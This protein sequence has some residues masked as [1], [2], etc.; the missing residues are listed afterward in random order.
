M[1]AQGLLAAALGTTLLLAEPD[2]A[3]LTD[4]VPV[5]V[6]PAALALE[7]GAPANVRLPDGTALEL[8]VTARRRHPSGNV[9]VLAR[10]TDPA[11][12][13][14][15][16]TLTGRPETGLAGTVLAPQGEYRLEAREG[17]LQPPRMV[18]VV[19]P[20]NAWLDDVA[21][22]A[23][24]ASAPAVTFDED[25]L[26]DEHTTPLNVLVLY[27]AGARDGRN[28]AEWTA[29]LDDLF[30]VT[31]DAYAH[32]GAQV[33]FNRVGERLVAASESA[34]SF[35][36]LSQVTPRSGSF[37]AAVFGAVEDWRLAADAH[38]VALLRRWQPSQSNCGAAGLQACG[39]DAQCYNANLGYSVTSLGDCTALTLA[40]E[41][42]HNLGSAH[43]PGL[44]WGGTYPYAH[45]HVTPG[46]VGTVMSRTGT[47]RTA[48]FSSPVADCD[49]YPCG[50]EEV[51]DN[52][53][54][55][56]QSRH[57]I[58]RWISDRS[59]T[60]WDF[61]PAQVTRGGSL[62]LNFL[63]FGVLTPR[64]HIDLHRDGAAVAR[65]A[66]AE[67]LPEGF[68][69]LAIPAS[70][71][72]GTGYSLRVTAA[73]LPAIYT[74]S[75]QFELVPP[76]GPPGVIAMGAA[77]VTAPQGA[78][79]VELT[80]HRTG[81][82]AG[83]A[84]VEFETVDGTARAGTHY[85]ATTGSFA[86]PDGADGAYNITVPITT[87]AAQG[88]DRTFSVVLRNPSA[89]TTL[90]TPAATVVTIRAPAGG[91]GG[92]GGGGSPGP[93]SLLLAA[94]L[95]A[96]PAGARAGRRGQSVVA[97]GAGVGSRMM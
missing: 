75:G 13:G 38:L 96:C 66:D 73:D 42:G 41:L 22:H 70:L 44:D 64:F 76:A 24:P 67:S 86:W 19:P 3:G 36:L 2:A 51:S 18:R 89:G 83:L 47:T 35:E 77:A 6:D 49:G 81:G 97:S 63:W 31:N 14:Y 55:L 1:I 95:L 37:D 29:F 20:A 62:A 26:S 58:A 60:L 57:Y 17:A 91:G 8:I 11:Q 61:A 92:G 56:R 32:S 43:E 34:G 87:A 52:V 72:L 74:E 25:I 27:T 7:T 54:S 48:Q 21:W 15:L 53:R 9:T 84:V 40:H 68:K 33:E 79:F 5:R 85:T 69:L 39:D 78:S 28:D 59:I 82:T 90:G 93:W 16:V 4:E 71:P 88:Q 12:S 80:V 10:P 94:A 23:R 30:A 65:L 45:A 50:I 46:G